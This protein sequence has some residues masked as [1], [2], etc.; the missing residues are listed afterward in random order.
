MMKKALMA[1]A[2]SLVVGG[3]AAAPAAYAGVVDFTGAYEPNN[4]T[5]VLTGTPP[6][7]GGASVVHSA[8]T[9][10]INGGNSDPLGC[11]DG[12]C[13]VSR[14]IVTPGPDRHLVF[15]WDYNSFDAEG[16]F[17]FFGYSINGIRTQLTDAGSGESHQ[18]G[19]A[20]VSLEVGSEFGFYI[21]CFDCVGGNA[22]VNVTG[23]Q[24][25]PEPGSLA[26]LGL[27]LAGLAGLRRRLA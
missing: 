25:A 8:T 4:W 16:I 21:D 23:F 7:G 12:P 10:T 22:V 1:V 26:L 5:T 18:F 3:L 14:N 6:G 17:D 13:I 9:L 24:A 27:G 20:V 2:A 15:H 11:T 19:D